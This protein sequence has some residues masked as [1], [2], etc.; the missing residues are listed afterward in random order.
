MNSSSLEKSLFCLHDNLWIVYL[1]QLPAFDK[2]AQDKTGLVK[3]FDGHRVTEMNAFEVKF[4]DFLKRA[5]S[6][7]ELREHYI[8]LKTN[9]APELFLDRLLRHLLLRKIIRKVNSSEKMTAFREFKPVSFEECVFLMPDSLTFI[10]EGNWKRTPYL[11]LNPRGGRTHFMDRPE[12]EVARYVQMAPRSLDDIEQYYAEGA[13]KWIGNGDKAGN[14]TR[15][16][17]PEMLLDNLLVP[18]PYNN[19]TVRLFQANRQKKAKP[20][21]FV[22]HPTITSYRIQPRGFPSSIALIPTNR[23]NN[24]C[25]HCSAFNDEETYKDILSYSCLCRLMDEMHYN[26]LKILRFTGGEPFMR[27]DILDILDYAS[28]KNFGIM[29]YTNGNTITNKNIDRIAAIHGRKEGNFLVHLSLDGDRERHD[30]FRRTP[31]AFDRVMNTMQLFARHDIQYYVEMVIHPDMLKGERLEN[32]TEKVIALNSRALLTHPAL[33]IGRGKNNANEICVDYEQTKVAW[34]KIH[35]LQKKFKGYDLRFKHYELPSAAYIGK[36][37]SPPDIIRDKKSVQ[38][39]LRSVARPGG[40]QCTAGVKQMTI[41][42]DGGVYPCPGWVTS[43]TLPIG[44]ILSDSIAA[45]WHNNE[46]WSMTRGG[47][48]YDQ[49]EVCKECSHLKNCELGKLCRIPS[50]TWFGTPYG[51]P[52]SCIQYWNNVGLSPIVVRDFLKNVR[53]NTKEDFPIESVFSE[54]DG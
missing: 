11:I 12:Y 42:H 14:L 28:T 21:L 50:L 47:W 15:E 26:G 44:N 2:L 54:I 25:K 32:I 29:L 7:H 49:I 18:L 41:A 23:C 46:K 8:Q 36:K 19:D 38:S 39:R 24:R 6:Y 22:H 35:H 34:K 40:G 1:A 17:L 5:R 52:P 10:D 3:A 13:G 48:D 31:G 51:P 9:T 37:V 30:S 4:I 45:I 16:L 43:G 27:E 53:K 33:A 20:N